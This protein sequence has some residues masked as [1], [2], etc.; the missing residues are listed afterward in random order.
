MAFGGSQGFDRGDHE[1]GGRLAG[2]FFG[3]LDVVEAHRNR[4]PGAG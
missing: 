4:Q 2:E 3:G 1:I